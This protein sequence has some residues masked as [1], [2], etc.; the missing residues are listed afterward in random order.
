MYIK[1]KTLDDL[2][3]RVI[4]KLLA[5][6]NKIV[7]HRGEAREMTGVLLHITNP[8]SR[9]SRTEKKGHIFSCLGELLWY[10]SGSNAVDFISYY[11]NRYADES[12]DGQTIYG[13]YG[14]RLFRMAGEH[15]QVDNVLRLLRTS[16]TS[17]RAV[18]QLF[19]AADIAYRHK[20]VPCTC[21]LQFV[22]RDGRVHM[23]TYMRS[24][25]AFLGLPHDVFAFTMLQEIVARS[26]GFDVG[27]YKHAVGSL[28]L[29][30]AHSRDAEEY[31]AEGFQERVGMP[32]M[33]TGDPRR[34]IREVLEAELRIRNDQAVDVEGSDLASYW[35]D[36]IRLLQVFRHYKNG[37]RAKIA[38]VMSRMSSPIF[39]PYIEQK[40]RTAAKRAKAE[41]KGQLPLF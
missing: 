14:P 13:G 1:E 17:R 37:E 41:P 11:V 32:P 26:L 10:L 2:L 9:L 38:R 4:S 20:E 19:D 30:D 23:F 28:H 35:K 16:P 33:P 36:L 21:T 6:K 3:H 12:D 18:I 25:D 24:N 27:T 31:I 29:Y 22:V 39:I 40:R 7:A 5:T 15:D 34:S 8:R